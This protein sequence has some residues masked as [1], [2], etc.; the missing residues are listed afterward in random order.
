MR[1]VV[2]E[3]FDPV[4]LGN[5]RDVLGTPHDAEVLRLP[6]GQN[7]EAVFV[8][9][10]LVLEVVR[11]SVDERLAVGEVVQW[12]HLEFVAVGAGRPDEEEV[13][14]VAAVAV[15]VEVEVVVLV[16]ELGLL[17]GQIVDPHLVE[18]FGGFV[19]GGV[20]ES[21]VVDAPLHSS[22]EEFRDG[23]FEGGQRNLR[24]GGDCN[25]IHDYILDFIALPRH[26]LEQLL[27]VVRYCHVADVAVVFALG[28]CVFVQQQLI[29]LGE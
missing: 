24:V 3:E 9:T 6:V 22:E 7:D 13:V 29:C 26:L 15:H 11:A 23:V 19:V 14:V 1:R 16:D 27:V 21:V 18:V 25:V 8:L 12:D 5:S 2:R 17:S 10:E 28:Q 20:E 4:V